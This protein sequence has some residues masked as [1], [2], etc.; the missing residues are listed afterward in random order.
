[1][2]YLVVFDLDGTLT[3]G[4]TYVR[5]LFGYLV[6]HP[7]RFGRV[8]HLPWFVLQFYLGRI[9]NT[10][11]KEKFLSACLGGL[12]RPVLL[13]WTE[14]F[15]DKLFASG[16]REGGLITLDQHQKRG[17]VLVLLTASLDLYVDQVGSRLG[18]HHVICSRVEWQGNNLSGRLSGP[19]RYGAEKVRCLQALKKQYRGYTV[20][21]YADHHSDIPLLQLADDGVLVNGTAR[22]C[23]LARQSGILQRVWTS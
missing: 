20:I 15:L 18:F 22:S 13:R 21:A 23:R 17:D 10:V 19:N 5:Y 6:R 8:L 3:R 4:D 1:M 14:T 12:E 7:W 11:L 9:T 16:F 2:R